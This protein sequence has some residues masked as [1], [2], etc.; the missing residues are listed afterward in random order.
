MSELRVRAL[1]VLGYALTGIGTASA[2]LNPATGYELSIYASTPALFWVGSTV[3]LLVSI[4]VVFSP[5]TR[6]P[7]MLG[8]VLGGVGM[9]SIVSLPIIRGYYY[10]GEADALSHLG[11]AME[12]HAGV[13]GFTENRYP[14]V[15]T[16]GVV[17]HDVTGLPLRH[18]MLLLIVVFIACFFVFVPLVVRELTDDLTATY[19]GLFSGFLLLPINHLAPSYRVHPTSQ[20]ILFAPVFLFAFLLLYKNRTWP[21]SVMFLLLAPTFVLLH[22]QQAASLVAFFGVIAVIQVLYDVRSGR[23]G[24]QMRSWV[25]PEVAAYAVTFWLW[26][27][28]LPV[29]Q[30]NTEQVI[31][32]LAGEIQFAESTARRTGSLDSVGGSLP[33]VFMKLFFV[34]TAYILLT[35]VVLAVVVASVRR[36]RSNVPVDSI[37]SDGGKEQIL[38]LSLFGGLVPVGLLFVIYLVGGLSDQYF[39]H[40]GLLM[41]FGTV[42][43]AIGIGLV[44]RYVR[45]QRS[46]TTARRL[47]VVALVVVTALSLPVVFSS[48][49]IYDSSHHVTEAQVN[50]Y[51]TTFEYRAESIVFDD[52]RSP[53]FRYGRTL[54]DSS[55]SETDF[56]YQGCPDGI[57]DHFNN[58]SLRAYYEE[59]VYV[60]VTGADKVRDPELWDGFRFNH[61]DFD[62]LRTEPGIDRVQ[63]NGEYALYRVE[64]RNSQQTSQVR[65]CFPG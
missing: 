39:R 1:L 62:Y 60:P 8:A 41:M 13:R 54:A 22:P 55:A 56:Y 24:A 61:S 4:L 6:G 12:M 64:P 18:T 3:A 51:E 36:Y 20:A 37:A 25:L 46:A 43:G 11:T 35:G 57:P 5:A 34:S 28:Q 15:H 7:R 16:V 40:L 29:F 14:V 42:L 2:Y 58:Q 21:R 45:Q 19:V 30:Q 26:V 47:V 33:E 32:T 48:P 17:L 52:V 38:L 59:P 63:A 53:V 9:L 49:Y 23:A 27:Q 31:E 65:Q 50:G 44:V 10:V